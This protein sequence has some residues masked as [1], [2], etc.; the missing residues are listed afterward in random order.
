M[1]PFWDNVLVPLWVEAHLP[2]GMSGPFGPC[3]AMAVEHEGDVVAGFVFHNWDPASGTM[4]MSGASTTPRWG[5]R[6]VVRAGM[7]YVFD[8]CGCQMLYTKQRLDNRAAR[9][10]LLKLGGSEVIV[11]RM[12]GR[13]THGTIVTLTDDQ[14][15]SSRFGGR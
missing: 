4:E 6:Y 13:E 9:S 5:T 2:E 11:P 14:W 10:G 1:T 15:R 7:E 8:T 3:Q 12:F